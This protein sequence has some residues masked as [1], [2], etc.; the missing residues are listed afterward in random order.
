V[1]AKVFQKMLDSSIWLESDSTVRVWITFLLSM[2][3]EG[4]CAFASIENLARRARVKPSLTAKAVAV[5]E[6][7]DEQSASKDWDGRRIERVNG[8][9]IVLN[10]KK[11]R[12]ITRHGDLRKSRLNS[13]Q[14]GATQR[15]SAQLGTPIDL[16][17]NGISESVPEIETEKEIEKVPK[18]EFFS[19][20]SCAR[21]VTENLNLSGV[22]F[23]WIAK[24]AIEVAQKEM[25]LNAQ[26]ASEFIVEAWAEYEKTDGL[27]GKKSF[28]AE[29][30]FLPNAKWRKRGETKP[31]SKLEQLR[32]L[33]A[34]D[35]QNGLELEEQYG[36]PG[37][38][39]SPR[40]RI[41]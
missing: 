4:F 26:A 21:Y 18:P 14:T 20:Q 19:S 8:G 1:F 17:S 35:G 3:S 13:E 37:A 30:D 28:L 38:D 10:C 16:S 39:A 36:G 24:D 11:Y 22:Q 5:L 25:G 2:D 31:A 32:A 23:H 9:W 40:G 12:E 41:P 6:S 15:N 34:A 7:P 29:S 27:K 33:R